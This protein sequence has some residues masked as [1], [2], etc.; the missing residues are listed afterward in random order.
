MAKLLSNLT[1]WIK[2]SCLNSIFK[3]EG[4]MTKDSQSK[5]LD[6]LAMDKTRPYSD[7]KF[8]WYIAKK[9]FGSFSS[10]S[11]ISFVFHAYVDIGMFRFLC[12]IHGKFIIGALNDCHLWHLVNIWIIHEVLVGI[13]W[14]TDV[15]PPR[16]KPLKFKPQLLLTLLSSL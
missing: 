3:N 12:I 6:I 5:F 1:H 7:P 11:C 13:Q 10:I 2:R 16:L 4:V 9:L 14:V 8:T 15:R